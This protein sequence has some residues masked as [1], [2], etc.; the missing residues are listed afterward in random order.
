MTSSSSTPRKG[1]AWLMGCFLLLLL[2]VGVLAGVAFFLLRSE[3]I[4]AAV[5]VGPVVNI[6]TPANGQR[7]ERNVPLLVQARAEYSSR[8]SR[9]E[10][11]ADGALVAVQ[12][13]T[14][15]EGSNPLVFMQQWTPTTLGRHVLMARAYTREGKFADSS[16]VYV[17]VVELLTPSVSVN[18]DEIPRREGSPPP[19]LTDIANAS[20]IPLDRLREA[21]P[22]IDP[23]RP[24]TPGTP[25]EI[26]RSPA[27]P[28]P[29]SG[30][31]PTPTPSPMP[32]APAAPTGLLATADCTSITLNWSDAPNEEQYRVYR[33]APGDARLNL[34]ATLAANTITYRDTLPAPGTY[35][36]Q[37][38]SVRG[39]LEGLS[40]MAEAR[41][42]DGCPAPGAPPSTLRLVIAIQAV[43]TT[44]VFERG[45]Y[46]YYQI[47]TLPWD[48]V[49]ATDA[50]TP[51]AGNPRRYDLT[52]LPGGGRFILDHIEA[53]P[54]VI[55][56]DCWGRTA[57]ES[58]QLHP[59]FSTNHPRAEWDGTVRDLRAPNNSFTVKYCISTSLEGCR[60]GVRPVS[61]PPGVD[62]VP[63]LLDITRSLPAPRNL[64]IERTLDVCAELPESERA[65]CALAGLFSGG[66]PTLRWDWSGAPFYSEERIRGYHVVVRANDALLWERD[67]RPG[68]RKMTFA[69]TT[70]LPCGSHIAYEV[71]A[72]DASGRQSE[73]SDPLEFET[74]ACPRAMELTITYRDLSVGPSARRDGVVDDGDICIL[75][76]D[77]RLELF[78]GFGVNSPVLDGWG[79]LGTI[80]SVRNP[81]NPFEVAG[82]VL[83]NIIGTV[84]TVFGGC[85]PWTSC[86]GAGT[87]PFQDQF[88]IRRGDIFARRSNNT[89]TMNL[90]EG[91]TLT[92]AAAIFDF[93]LLNAPDAWCLTQV[94]VDRRMEE[95]VGTHTFTLTDDRGEASCRIQVEVQGRAR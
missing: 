69:R 6:L 65:A 28:T 30:G 78:G 89:L 46:C 2:L 74:L 73:P 48:R 57:T 24:I 5:S 80:T 52:R 34:I 75:C 20:G 4:S 12:A 43:E 22:T 91:Q 8:I 81:F 9:V 70:D 55:G 51:V 58:R 88:L 40:G 32:G 77:R 16:I 53:N 82:H 60:G 39:G 84:G 63:P 72:V 83:E 66:F 14:L 76:T 7:A 19:S 15:P 23:T 18:V 64:R 50:L 38:A 1:C 61:L 33:I 47:N 36:Y 35:R 92:L 3:T 41:T 31:T 93:D 56:L 86:F 54:V 26:P 27:T 11:Y 62:V 85:P 44:E 10:L 42:P 49:P 87:Y 71:M 13:S 21:N 17:D 25:V 68:T 59:R 67:I 95:W 90:H 45:V 37:V 29:P 79:W 94:E